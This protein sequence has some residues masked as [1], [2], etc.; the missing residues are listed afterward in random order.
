MNLLLNA[1]QAAPESSAIEISCEVDEAMA[2]IRIRD[3]GPGMPDDVMS[4]ATDPFF[5]TKPEGEGTGL[6]LA[7]TLSVANAHGG[8]LSFDT[9]PGEG[10]TAVLTL[11]RPQDERTPS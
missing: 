2:S 5:S 9:E 1:V 3:H 7:V 4:R 6:G 8:T 10:T 11:P